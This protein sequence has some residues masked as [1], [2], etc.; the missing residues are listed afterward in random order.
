M[1]ILSLQ[2]SFRRHSLS[3]KLH[4]LAQ[5]E[6]AVCMRI[7]SIQEVVIATAIGTDN[8]SFGFILL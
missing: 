8:N 1:T 3:D 6:M 7:G 5:R 4:S 2:V